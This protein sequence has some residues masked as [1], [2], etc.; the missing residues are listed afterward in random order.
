MVCAVSAATFSSAQTLI[1]DTV[2]GGGRPGLSATS[3]SAAGASAVAL[4]ASG[5]MYVAVSKLNQ[6]WVVS[7]SGA[8]TEVIGNGSPSYSGDG[9]AAISAGLN[10]PE[11]VALDASGNLYIADTYNHRIRKVTA[12]KG[13]ISTVAG[14]GVNGY[15]GDQ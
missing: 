15:S 3:Y 7:P 14:T 12:A 8:V 11:G 2:A 6:I 4:D 1:I 9:G 13:I 10:N 5:N